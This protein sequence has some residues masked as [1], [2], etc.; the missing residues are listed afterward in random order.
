[1]VCQPERCGLLLRRG[2]HAFN[3]GSEA[4]GVLFDRGGRAVELQEVV[5]RLGRLDD[6]SEHPKVGTLDRLSTRK[7]PAGLVEVGAG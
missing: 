5:A 6:R 1:M 7:G 2:N 3:H 4:V